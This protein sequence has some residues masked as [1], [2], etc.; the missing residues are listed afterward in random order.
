MCGALHTCVLT[1]KFRYDLQSAVN[2]LQLGRGDPTSGKC[3]CMRLQNDRNR[4]LVF[5]ILPCND[6]LFSH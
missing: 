3:I 4:Y 5:F 2:N 6:A 1:C